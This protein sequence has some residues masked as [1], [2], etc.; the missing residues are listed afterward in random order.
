MEQLILP[1][2]QPGNVEP[3][4]N[5]ASNRSGS[6][7][8]N[9]RGNVSPKHNDDIPKEPVSLSFNKTAFSLKHE[10][11]IREALLRS[12]FRIWFLILINKTNQ[13]LTYRFAGISPCCKV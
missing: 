4:Q 10:E 6:Q 8:N 7:R 13:F 1:P 11:C 3:N 2:S 9:V 12:K 5:Q